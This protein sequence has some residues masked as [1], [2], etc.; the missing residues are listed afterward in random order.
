MEEI[1]PLVSPKLDSVKVPFWKKYP[2]KLRY[3]VLVLILI[4]A[5]FGAYRLV[6]KTASGPKWQ[7]LP[8]GLVADKVS[9]SAAIVV[10]LPDSVSLTPA[11][12][13]TAINFDPKLLGSWTAGPTA[14]ELVFKPQDKLPLNTYYHVTL[15]SAGV[16]LAKDF[17]AVE[18]PKIVIILPKDGSEAPETS[19]ITVA[20]NRPMVPLT[21]LD[22]QATA[23]IPVT[24]TP[25]TAG[26]FKWISTRNLQFIPD[27]RLQR[28]SNYTVSVGNG[29]TSMDG[30]PLDATTTR[31]TTRPLRYNADTI[32]HTGPTLYDEPVGIQFTQPVDINK[33]IGLISVKNTG[34][35]S[36]VPFVAEY[37]TRSV[38]VGDRGGQADY[39]D[40]SLIYVYQKKDKFGRQK[41]WDNNTNYEVTIKG[42]FPAEGDINLTESRT[43]EVQVPDIVASV[44]ADSPRSSLVQPG[45]FDPKGH[46][47]LDFYEDIDKDKSEFKAPNYTGASYAQVCKLDADGNQIMNGSDCQKQD[48]KK[49]LLLSF[50][51]SGFQ[52]G[53]NFDVELVK[54]VNAKGLQLNS[55]SIH[56]SVTVYPK[57]QVLKT[58]PAQGEQ[59]ASVTDL[60]ICSNTPIQDAEPENFNQILKSNVT[61]GK[62]TWQA[63]YVVQS[64]DQYN[65][66]KCDVGQY[67]SHLLYGLHPQ[68]D[69]QLQLNLPDQFGQTVS[70]NLSFTSGKISSLQTGFNSLQ[71]D[72]NVTSPGRTKLTYATENLDYVDLTVCQI[73]AQ[74]MLQ[75]L[76][77]RPADSTPGQNL[78]CL[79]TWQ[80]NITWAPKYWDL[81]YFQFDLQDLV[82]NPLGYY[83]LSFSNPNL[84]GTF[85]DPQTG[86]TSPMAMIYE[87]TLLNVTNLAAQEKKVE[88]ADGAAPERSVENKVL[89][90]SQGNL[91][92]VTQIGSMDPVAGAAV[93]V[94]QLGKKNYNLFASAQTGQDGIA[95]ASAYS[96]D[97]AAIITFGNDSTLVSSATDKFQ[98]SSQNPGGDKTYIYSDRPIYRP[99]QQVFIKGL[100]R[101]GYDGVYEIF[102][103]KSASLQINDSSNT[104]VFNQDLKISS[105]GTFAASFTLPSDAKLG[106]YSVQALGGYYSFDVQDYVPAAFKLDLSADKDEYIAGD[107]FNLNVNANYYFGVPVEGGTVEYSVLAQ[108]YYF[109]RY[110]DQTFQFGSAWYYSPSPYY[111]DN[112]ILRGKANLDNLGKATITQNLDFNKLFSNDDD[113]KQ[114]KIFDVHVTVKNSTGQS[115]SGEQSFIVHRG[116]FYLG[117]NLQKNYFG[118]NDANKILIKSVDTKGKEMSVS[119]ITATVNKVTWQY[120]KRQEVDGGYYYNST[121]QLKQ[122][123]TFNA[124]TDGNG[125]FS[126]DFTVKDE[127]EYEL[128]LTAKDSRGNPITASQSFYVYGSGTVDVQPLNNDSLDIAVPSNQVDVGQTA[129][130]VIKSPF[131]KAKALIAIESGRIMDYQIVDVNSNFYEY[132]FPVKDS[133]YPNFYATVLLLSP[134]PQ[135]KF[136]QVAYYVNTKEK[137]ITVEAKPD[138]S[139]Y[140]PGEQVVLDVT[141]KDANGQPVAAD[142]SLSVADLSVLAL[143]GNPKKDPVSFFYDGRPLAVTTSSNLK[144]IL[145]QA[146]IPSG[147]KGGSGAEPGDLATKKRG[148][149][150]D[151]AYWNSD[152]QTDSSGH[153][154]VKFTLPDNLTTWQIESLGITNDTKLGVGYQQFDAKKQLMVTP[155]VP[156]FVI[157]G[158]EFTVG[159]KVFN[160]TGSRQQ[161]TVSLDSA[162]LNI[163]GGKTKTITLDAGQTQSV[164]FTVTAPTSMDSGTETLNITAKNNN[165]TDSVDASFPINPNQTYEA[166]STSNYTTDATASEYVWLPKNVV[167]NKGGVTIKSSATLAGVIPEALNYLV[168]YPYGCTEQMMSKITAVATAKRFTQIKNLGDK[169]KLPDVQFDG[170]TYSADDVVSIGEAR[171]MGNQNQDGGFAYYPQMASD[172]YL[173]LDVINALEQL[174]QA[175]Y[176]VNQ[177][178]EDR[179]AAYITQTYN[180]SDY[181]YLDNNTVILTAYTLSN[182]PG[183]SA[184]AAVLMAKVV[185]LSNDIKFMNEDVSNLSLSYMALLTAKNQSSVLSQKVF[186]TLEN[187]VQVDGRGAYL[188]AGNSTANLWQYY[189]TP[190]KDTA[191]LI[192][193]E[194]DSNRTFPMMDKLIRWL[195]NSR[196]ADGSWGTTSN[197]AAVLDALVDYL[198]FSHENLSD[199]AL[200]LLVDSNNKGSATFN[201]Q[202]ILGSLDVSLP[203]S[204]FTPEKLSEIKFVKTNNNTQPNG[205][206]YDMLL[207]YYLP[208]DSIAPRDEGFTVQREMYGLDDKTGKTPLSSAKVGDVLRGHLTITVTKPRNFVAVESFIPAGMQLVNFNLATEDKN[209]ADAANAPLNNQTQITAAPI[210]TPAP[211]TIAKPGFFTRIWLWIKGWFVRKSALSPASSAQGDLPDEVYS[212]NITTTDKLMPDSTEFHDDRLLL[213][214]QSL[215]PGVYQYD[216]FVR[217]LIPGKF[218]HLPAVASELYTPENFG[219]SRGEYFT[220][221]Q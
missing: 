33:T 36:D 121:K 194:S 172:Y 119:G 202:N 94:Y 66:E 73:S 93:Q 177:S 137:T 162:T 40:K 144:N 166:V 112:F 12:A 87:R 221:T 5:G 45:L 107:N 210:P 131:T 176:K 129:K 71:K 184:E 27:T 163:T 185:S 64:K 20:F 72:Y 219:R 19:S 53:Q 146:Q 127:G 14:K 65:N 39:V 218:Q 198:N 154:Q 80:K 173:T 51:D 103:G 143:E 52:P 174:K 130:M 152:A 145:V 47:V 95:R 171:I 211:I 204:D 215:D 98:W 179:A 181:L 25:K 1:N 49:E 148:V 200:N 128:D 13:E 26:K 158:D 133:Y 191:L 55:Q 69:Y 192:K 90:D 41:F 115:V 207:K 164:Y 213:F 183:Q 114:S 105:Q 21:S 111:G 16:T 157:P 42:A 101:I 28:S 205:Y 189:E 212:G 15:A 60:V 175:G 187:R 37:G 17:Q 195:Q 125:N 170:G 62:W 217:A 110:T 9:Q 139:H 106:T 108:D 113:R 70:Q 61:V 97:G 142:V 168:D 83:V 10:N 84:R 29:F 109:D 156:L 43:V 34:N 6:L 220:I 149:F 160:Q 57:P 38:T 150:K 161:F 46:L 2:S 8:Q 214:N 126:Q 63:P 136:G 123:Q 92:W 11:Q 99:G 122:V 78:N 68:T 141:T 120:D 134:D 116:Q 201:S 23:N 31:F 48:N 91:Y 216:Y 75:Y 44:G 117:A 82:P 100:Y 7:E 30:L 58:F 182:V 153:A 169:F 180:S 85:Y 4:A 132:S 193:A 196:S 35:N 86:K 50:N 140:L 178:A 199:F 24:I 3:A 135:V 147:T 159:G 206:Y 118:V 138:K 79:Q 208:V 188:G 165:F 32:H 56:E 203:M 18:D 104:A 74:S 77:T 197:T 81:N 124:N 67:G 59:N 209:L 89:N 167:P 190:I 22:Q 186:T 96:G 155:L 54:I 102:Q 151:T 76:N 88:V